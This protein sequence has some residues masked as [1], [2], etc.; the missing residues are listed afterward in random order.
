MAQANPSDAPDRPRIGRGVSPTFSASNFETVEGVKFKPP[1]QIRRPKHDMIQDIRVGGA[2]NFVGIHNWKQRRNACVR[3]KYCPCGLPGA[4]SSTTSPATVPT[5]RF[6]TPDS[7]DDKEHQREI[8]EEVV[9]PEMTWDHTPY[10]VV[11]VMGI[12]HPVPREVLVKIVKPG[13]MFKE[14]RVAERYVRPFLRRLLS[15]KHTAGF[16]IYECHATRSSHTPIELDHQT[17]L[18]LSELYL[19]YE[20]GEPDY[21]SRWLHWTQ[22]ELNQGTTNPADGR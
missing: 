22:S 12:N 21:G 5:I 18:I 14:I 16:G 15:L 1:P 6:Y 4:L 7:F 11:G 3:T 10:I 13:S 9:P 17:K 8:G 20:S 19:D 2:R